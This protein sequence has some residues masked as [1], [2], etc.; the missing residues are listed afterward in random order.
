M[1]A[2]RNLIEALG[3]QPT[4]FNTL[5]IGIIVLGSLLAVRKLYK[6]LTGPP[7][8]DEDQRVEPI[9]IKLGKQKDEE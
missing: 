2:I 3:I 4:T 8:D 9:K 5:T 1:D 6:D 7:L